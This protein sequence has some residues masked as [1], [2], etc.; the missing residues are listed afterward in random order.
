MSNVAIG[1]RA[2]PAKT[3]AIP[4]ITRPA[5][6]WCDTAANTPPSILIR[7]IDVP[8][9]AVGPHVPEA[10]NCATPRKLLHPVSLI[11]DYRKSANFAIDLAKT[12]GAEL[13][14]LHVLN[15][16]AN[17][18]GDRERT[19]AWTED[20]LAAF[21]ADARD[22]L[23]RIETSLA[24]GSVVEEILNSAA[25]QH[26]DWIVLGVGG[27]IPN[28][29]FK[30]SKAYKVLA[31]ANCPIMTIRHDH[32]GTEETAGVAGSARATGRSVAG[33]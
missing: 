16:A 1:T 28:W 24:T 13:I 21:T 32:Q 3:A 8:V 6:E 14:L 26:P 33:R 31:S 27:G 25:H 4:T 15:P 12:Y 11:G 5:G 2:A 19:L 23:P 29:P 17:Y 22:I 20:P 7:S 18:T 9:F 10:A 30:D